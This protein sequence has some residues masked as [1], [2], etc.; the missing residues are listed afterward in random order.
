[1]PEVTMTPNLQ[2]CLFH[3]ELFPAQRETRSSLHF[4]PQSCFTD[5]N[6]ATSNHTCVIPAIL[7]LHTRSLFKSLRRHRLSYKGCR[8]Y[9]KYP[10]AGTLHHGWYTKKNDTYYDLLTVLSIIGPL[11]DILEPWQPAFSLWSQTPTVGFQC[12]PGAQ[13]M[14]R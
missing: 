13:D 2:S 12:S 10:V 5:A 14:T 9:T 11:V 6:T 1:M 7:E 4:P 3:C 8:F